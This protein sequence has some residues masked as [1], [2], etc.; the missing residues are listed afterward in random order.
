MRSSALV[1][2]AWA[3]LTVIAPPPLARGGAGEEPV[4]LVA[5]DAQLASDLDGAQLAA[6]NHAV[7]GGGA[8]PELD[9]DLGRIQQTVL[10]N[11][12]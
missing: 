2:A 4:E 8:D 12:H 7:D 9:R 5:V 1:T 6:G 11:V 3:W 10:N